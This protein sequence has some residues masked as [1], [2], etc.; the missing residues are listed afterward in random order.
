MGSSESIQSSAVADLPSLWRDEIGF[1]NWLHMNIEVLAKVLDLSLL[2][3]QREAPV[4]R[5]SADILADICDSTERVI[6]EN[7]IYAANHGHF[8]QVLTYAA[9]YD[10]QVIVWIA[11]TFRSEYRTAIAWLNGLSDKRFYAVELH[12]DGQ[13]LPELSLVAGPKTAFKQRTLGTEPVILPVSPHARGTNQQGAYVPASYAI[14]AERTASPGQLVLNAIFERIAQEL[15]GTTTF[16]ALRKPTGDR[17]YYVVATGPVRASE[18]AIAF[19]N[20]QVGVMLVFNDPNTAKRDLDRLREHAA[21]V[22]RAVD[23][24]V[25]MGVVEHRRKQKAIIY[26]PMSYEERSQDAEGVARWCADTITTFKNA[27]D[28]LV[29]F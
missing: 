2:S 26:R 28:A 9:H 16:P 20:A 17:N 18:W 29:L 21:E 15:A 3:R 19:E 8:G 14:P 23:S 25:D 10:A 11:S 12:G 1:S 5:L 7:Q 27:V 4:G 22:D 13:E 6:I 24:S